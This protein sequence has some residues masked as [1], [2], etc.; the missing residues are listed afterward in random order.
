MDLSKISEKFKNLISKKHVA[1]IIV[2]MA[3]L[4]I[5]LIAYSDFFIKSSDSKNI[6]KS[7]LDDVYVNSAQVELTEEDVLESKLKTILENM[8]GVGQ[9]EVMI[10]LEMGSEIIPASNIVQ[11]YDTTEENDSNG[12]VRVMTSQSSTQ[13]I[14]ISNNN[15]GT[16]QKP[17]VLKEIKPQING[18]IV[19]AEGADDIEVKAKLYEAVKTVLQV[20]GHKVQIYPKN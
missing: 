20:P 11:S 9:V 3:V 2:V 10:T 14:V 7:P 13:N 5:A 17:I 16:S 8:R 15:S 4:V 12:G 19:V 18:V 6:M 1:N